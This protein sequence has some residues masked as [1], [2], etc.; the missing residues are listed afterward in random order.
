MS[1]DTVTLELEYHKF[2]QDFG[3]IMLLHIN[4]EQIYTKQVNIYRDNLRDLWQK[5][6]ILRYKKICDHIL[7]LLNLFHSKFDGNGEEFSYKESKDSC[8]DT[9]C[10][11]ADC[12]CCY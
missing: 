10:D 8:Y 1:I 5:F 12:K 11:D 7:C 3:N 2:V 6:N 9:D 4:E